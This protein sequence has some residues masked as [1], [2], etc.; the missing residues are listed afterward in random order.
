MSNKYY[1]LCAGCQ[2]EINNKSGLCAEC[3]NE[4]DPLNITINNTA[5]KNLL[6]TLIELYQDK[7]GISHNSSS[8]NRLD[9]S[10]L[11]WCFGSLKKRIKS[12]GK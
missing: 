9:V 4:I 2:T 8:L 7:L 10:E 5:I 1:A 12:E 11:D 3:R 6:I